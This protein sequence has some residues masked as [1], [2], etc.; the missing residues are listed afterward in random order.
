MEWNRYFLKYATG[1]R[2]VYQDLTGVQVIL[3]E[4]AQT[5]NFTQGDGGHIQL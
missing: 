3:K 1:K 2:K 5:V 4:F